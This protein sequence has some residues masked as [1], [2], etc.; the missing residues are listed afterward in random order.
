MD[1]KWYVSAAFELFDE[2]K[3][4][5]LDAL[6]ELVDATRKEPGCVD[7]ILTQDRMNPSRYIFL[8]VWANEAAFRE[9]GDRPHMKEFKKRIEG[10]RTAV[11]LA[12]LKQVL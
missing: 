2:S 10:K 1:E 8:E 5:A 12:T 11:T 6:K 9:H 7:Y 4:E 3:D